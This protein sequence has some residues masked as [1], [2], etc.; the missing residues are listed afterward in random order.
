[1]S[2]WVGA[3][4]RQPQPFDASQLYSSRILLCCSFGVSGSAARFS[5]G[6][7]LWRSLVSCQ[8]RKLHAFVKD[9]HPD[10]VYLET[11]VV[12]R[13]LVEQLEAVADGAVAEASWFEVRWFLR[14]RVRTMIRWIVWSQKLF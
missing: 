3:G 12:S 6:V 5:R 2:C 11:V 1:M 14:G 13:A 10:A 8:V 4:A 7:P 9:R